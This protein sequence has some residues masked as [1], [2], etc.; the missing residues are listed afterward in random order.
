MRSIIAAI[1]LLLSVQA[2][3]WTYYVVPSGGSDSND[4][5][6][7]GAAWATVKKACQTV[8]AGDTCFIRSGYYVETTSATTA[9]AWGTSGV[10]GGMAPVN[11]GSAGNEIVF[12][13]YPGDTRP[14]YVGYSAAGAVTTSWRIGALLVSQDYIVYDSIEFRHGG[15]GIYLQDSGSP[16]YITVKNCIIDSTMG[17]APQTGAADD[18]SG[19]IFHYVNGYANGG[20]GVT[21]CVYQNNEIFC[22][23]AWRDGLYKSA[24]N[25]SGM[26]LYGCDSCLITGNIIHD[27]MTGIRAKEELRYSEI[28]YNTLYNIANDAM[29][30]RQ[31]QTGFG[32]QSYTGPDHVMSR[33]HHNTVWNASKCFL[34]CYGVDPNDGS[35]GT[36]DDTLLYFYNNTCD[37]TNAGIWKDSCEQPLY[38]GGWNTNGPEPSWGGVSGQEGGMNKAYF[39]NNIFYNVPAMS[40]GDYQDRIGAFILWEHSPW[41]LTLIYED[42]N[43]LYGQG[44]GQYYA[45]NSTEYTLAQWQ[46]A[47]IPEM[48]A[49]QGAHSTIA[50]P[51]FVDAANH[52]YRLQAGSPAATG[53]KGGSFT[54]FGGTARAEIV[55]LPTYF[56]AKDPN[57]SSGSTTTRVRARIR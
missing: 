53:G 8:A 11:S 26:H 16:D 15:A 49:G 45:I 46:A 5:K 40:N 31:G 24:Y 36:S 47:S 23:G 38:G 22:C 30:A 35:P 13:G 51:L 34:V 1:I 14:I 7:L 33:W 21:G 17:S 52:D 54:F 28:S 9:S 50:D 18:N 55:T 27:E 44:T 2:S 32:S 25:T 57:A 39:F 12:K 29:R 19:G 3:A 56:G 48:V 42:Y 37:C 43:M 6:S 20:N 4:G 10:Q 41:A